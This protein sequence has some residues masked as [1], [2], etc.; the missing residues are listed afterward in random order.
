MPSRKQSDDIRKFLLEQIP[1]HPRDI[2]TVAMH[3]FGLS[4][5]AIHQ[6][7]DHLIKNHQVIKTGRTKGA[8]YSLVSNLNK[9]LTFDLQTGLTESMVW[10]EYLN[11]A[12]SILPQNVFLICEYAFGE[13]FNNALDHSNGTRF[14]V[15]TSNADH[16]IRIEIKDNGVGIFNKIQTAFNLETEQESILHLSKGKL[17][18]DKERHTGEGIFFTSRLMDTFIIWSGTL[19]YQTSMGGEDWWLKT[20]DKS[21]KGTDVVMF[22]DMTTPRTM[23]SVF[24]KFTRDDEDEIPRFDK[25]RITVALSKHGDERFVS[26]SQAKRLVSGLDQFQEILLDFKDVR[27]VG[28]GFVDEVFRVFQNRHPHIKIEY[29]NAND[30]VE[31]MIKR[32]L[33]TRG[34]AT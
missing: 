26:R 25:T 10:N 3:R 12:F 34:E 31:F 11:E 14:E 28:Q 17:T 15:I 30:D 7:L 29:T 6:H 27:T 9:H 19:T 4:R 2:A 16:E 13:I 33:P 24:R 20:E 21:F 18:T 8:H 5:P 22:L 32:G 23:E 1:K